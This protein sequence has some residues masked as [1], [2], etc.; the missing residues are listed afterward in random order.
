MKNGS[1]GSLV[2]GHLPSYRP[3]RQVSEDHSRFHRHCSFASSCSRSA[4][5]LL[6]SAAPS[7]ELCCAQHDILNEMAH[8]V[9]AQVREQTQRHGKSAHQ[10]G[11]TEKVFTADERERERERIYRQNL[12][13]RVERYRMEASLVYARARAPCL[14][15]FFAILCSCTH[16]HP[17]SALSSSLGHL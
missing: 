12:E 9:N 4:K 7:M 6:Y 3:Q 8:H 2:F 16:L 14:G 5:L 1:S 11:A 13:K 17:G 15:C 10:N